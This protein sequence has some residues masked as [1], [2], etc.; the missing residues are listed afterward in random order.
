MTPADIELHLVTLELSVDPKSLFFGMVGF[1]ELLALPV[2]DQLTIWDA[3]SPDL[4]AMVENFKA[5]VESRRG[6]VQ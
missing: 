3:M 2:A 4:L 6:A 1:D 5:E